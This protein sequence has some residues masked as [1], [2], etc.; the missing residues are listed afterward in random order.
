MV[1]HCKFY[2]FWN[3]IWDRKIVEEIVHVTRGVDAIAQAYCSQLIRVACGEGNTYWRSWQGRRDMFSLCLCL[4]FSILGLV[5]LDRDTGEKDRAK[6]RRFYLWWETSWTP[7]SHIPF[8]MNGELNPVM[9]F[10]GI[11]GI[12]FPT[13]MMKMQEKG[14]H[15]SNQKVLA[16]PVTKFWVMQNILMQ[17]L[18]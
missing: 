11:L 4:A 17:S 3:D 10:N 13:L 6:R 5:K 18:N 12:L 9:S 16:V 8:S 2:P 7:E 1:D 14:L 15:W